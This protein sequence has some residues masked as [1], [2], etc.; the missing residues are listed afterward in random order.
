MWVD[1]NAH[2]EL[3]SSSV[4]VVLSEAQE[5]SVKFIATDTDPLQ[6]KW[7]NGRVPYVAFGLH[8][9]KVIQ[10]NSWLCEL[11][12][13]LIEN[14]LSPIGEIGLDYRSNMPAFEMQSV[15][16]EGQ[17]CL[18]R[19]L[20]RPV[21]IHALRSHGDV[22]ASLKK[23]QCTRFVIHAFNGS[24]EIAN[25]YLNLGG[26]L[27]ASGL[28]TW[29]PVPRSVAVFQSIPRDRLLI[30]TDAPD[31]LPLGVISG[32]PNMLAINWPRSS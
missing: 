29:R 9:H 21:I 22:I 18:S 28:I 13:L 25:I 11:E 1:I 6:W 31:L 15:C 19:E 32:A 27:S 7:L 23:I 17:L 10:N 2:L 3:M 4:E 24:Q 26:Y 20:N 30:E 16:F 5:A 12:R 14:P 8:P